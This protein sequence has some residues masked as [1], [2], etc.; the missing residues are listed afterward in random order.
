[1]PKSEILE[2]VICKSSFFKKNKDKLEPII[3][4]K[5]D[6]NMVFVNDSLEK[7]RMNKLN[8]ERAI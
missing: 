6:Q 1:L 3:K 2:S 8:R 4:T 7:L 5:I